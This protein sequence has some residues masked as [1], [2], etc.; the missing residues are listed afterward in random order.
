MMAEKLADVILG[1]PP[2]PRSEAKVYIAPEW[3]TKQR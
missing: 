1:A 2:L 3:E